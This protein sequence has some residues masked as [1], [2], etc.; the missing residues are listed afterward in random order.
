MRVPLQR[1]AL[2]LF[3]SGGAAAD[4]WLLHKKASSQT[5]HYYYC[6]YIALPVCTR[7]NYEAA[8]PVENESIATRA[9]SCGKPSTWGELQELLAGIHKYF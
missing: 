1:T 9:T 7:R 6:P 4:R 5:R 8:G 2:S 3:H